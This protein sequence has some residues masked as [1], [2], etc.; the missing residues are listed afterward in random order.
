MSYFSDGVSNA[1]RDDYN[2]VLSVSCTGSDANQ[3]TMTN[4]LDLYVEASEQVFEREEACPH[5]KRTKQMTTM[6]T[7]IVDM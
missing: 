6:H 1:S 4:L 5:C 2:F 7:K 3:M